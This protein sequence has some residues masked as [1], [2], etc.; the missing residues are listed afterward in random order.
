MKRIFESTMST[1]GPLLLGDLVL[2]QG[3]ADQDIGA[4]K[5]LRS[6]QK[7]GREE[8]AKATKPTKRKQGEKMNPDD[9]D[10]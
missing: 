4:G 3:G 10:E 2:V 8:T 7:K 5:P 6:K 9:D 1:T